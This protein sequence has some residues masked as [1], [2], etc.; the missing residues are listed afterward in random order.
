M[1]LKRIITA[2][3]A[4]PLFL[5]IIVYGTKPVFSLLVLLIAGIGLWEYFSICGKKGLHLPVGFGV[6]L[7]SCLIL[8]SCTFSFSL[9]I[10]TLFLASALSL[11][12][13]ML[14][15]RSYEN[16][17]SAAG[18]F[19]TGIFYIPFFLSHFV[20]IRHLA[21][22]QIWII[23]L[24]AVVFAGDTAAYY[25][26]H[27]LGRHKLYTAVSPGKTIEGAAGGLAGSIG[28]AFLF[29]FYYFPWLSPALTLI[30]ASTLGIFAQ[31]GDLAESMLKRSAGVKDSGRILPGHGGVLDRMDGVIFAC[32]L[33]FY[34]LL[35]L[36]RGA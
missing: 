21:L 17:L 4:A 32:P 2:L 27:L 19:I 1:H 26:G 33:L 13:F 34:E 7:G 15:F 31:I 22:G 23:F 36:L 9:M 10:C 11:T 30:I 3:V 12:Y 29:R 16:V 6:F 20:L 18:I 28:A 5:V 14:H 35:F 24:L 25:V 8:A